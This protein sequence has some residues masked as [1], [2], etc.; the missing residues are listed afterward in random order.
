M[1]LRQEGGLTLAP[2]A[3]RIAAGLGMGAMDPRYIFSALAGLFAVVIFA[4]VTTAGH[5]SRHSPPSLIIRSG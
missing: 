5:I 1:T 4:T 2:T 3:V